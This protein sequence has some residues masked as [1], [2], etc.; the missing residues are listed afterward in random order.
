MYRVIN[1]ETGLFL[2]DDFTF[3]EV[4]EIGLNVTP[5]QGLYRPKWDG[6]KWVEDMTAEEIKALKASVTPEPTAEERLA[7]LEQALLDMM[8]GMFQ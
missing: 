6:E 4:V 2:R 7:G 8:G 5:A 3:D 1:K